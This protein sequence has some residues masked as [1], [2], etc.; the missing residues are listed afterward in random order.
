MEVLILGGV[1]NNDPVSLV[2]IPNVFFLLFS[3]LFPCGTL[4]FPVDAVVANLYLS[5][6]LWEIRVVGIY[7]NVM[8]LFGIT[9]R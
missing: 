8:L 2:G 5:P 4:A 9:G 3:L 6:I 7:G 1:E